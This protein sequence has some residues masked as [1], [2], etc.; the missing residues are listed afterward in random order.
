MSCAACVRRVEKALVRVPGVD[1]ANLNL[2]TE[3]AAVLGENI[4]AEALTASVAWAGYKAE[5][6]APDAAPSVTTPTSHA[7]S[8]PGT[9]S[10]A[11]EKR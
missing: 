8:W 2:A 11:P 1:E 4:D 7:Q 6:I 3:R 10:G 9:P 5:V